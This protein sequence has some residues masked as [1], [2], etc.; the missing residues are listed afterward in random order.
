MKKVDGVVM[1]VT[2]KDI[3]Q[4]LGVSHTTVYRAVNNKPGVS[5]ETRLKVMKKAKELNYKPN[6]IARGLVSKKTSFIGVIVPHIEA[7][8]FPKALQGIEDV[9]SNY[10]YDMILCTSRDDEKILVSRVAVL[11]E[12]MVEGIIMAPGVC[13][14]QAVEELINEVYDAGPPIVLFN[15]LMNNIKAPSV[16]VDNISAGYIATQ[17]LIELGHTR[18]LHIHGPSGDLTSRHRFSGYYKALADGHIDFDSELVV[19]A[20]GYSRD[21]GY[22]VL[23]KAINNGVTFTAVYA[24]CDD[25]AL[26]AYRALKENG[27]RVPQDVALVANDNVDAVMFC[28]VPISSVSYDRKAMGQ[29]A[30]ETLLAQING[31]EGSTVILEPE[32][33]VRDSTVGCKPCSVANL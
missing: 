5:E 27:I 3:A 9:I 31:E 23:C 28:E 21:V 8:D 22:E 11:R 15:V 29:V 16:V 24:Y 19:V 32:L 33:I 13:C 1:T 2:L 25:L 18:I 12:K 14:T 26:G 4:A 20:R 30:A 10:G 7:P 17:H 6:V